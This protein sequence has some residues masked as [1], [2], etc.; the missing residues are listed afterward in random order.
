M[1]TLTLK[2]FLM[3]KLLYKYNRSSQ[4]MEYIELV[5][6]VEVISHNGF[7]NA[8]VSSMKYSTRVL[9]FHKSLYSPMTISPS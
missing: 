7:K 4:A 1:L 9:R 2:P 5:G 6:D 3:V 8:Q